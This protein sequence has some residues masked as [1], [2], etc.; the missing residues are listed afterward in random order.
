MLGL[1][2]PV[3]YGI[4]A[5]AISGFVWGHGYM[6]GRDGKSEAVAA[7]VNRCEARIAGAKRAAELTIQDILDSVKDEPMPADL[8]DACKKSPLCRENR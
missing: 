3:S 2:S 7:E 4:A 8:A 6:K 5:L 1:F